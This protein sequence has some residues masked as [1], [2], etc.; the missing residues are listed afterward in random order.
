MGLDAMCWHRR[1]LKRDYHPELLENLRVLLSQPT[2]TEEANT[3]PL[4]LT[5]GEQG[6]NNS[7]RVRAYL[8]IHPGAKVR[9]VAEALSISVSTANK[10]MSRIKE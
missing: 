1:R 8:L 4:L 2:V 9:E 5:E 7:E 10:W 3:E 6:A